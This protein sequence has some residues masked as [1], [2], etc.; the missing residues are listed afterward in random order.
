MNTPK[1]KVKIGMGTENTYF[2]LGYQI[3]AQRGEEACQIGSLV[4]VQYVAN[5]NSEIKDIC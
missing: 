5:L 2:A 1:Y 4:I 3:I